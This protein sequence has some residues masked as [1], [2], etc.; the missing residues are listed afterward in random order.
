MAGAPRTVSR[1]CFPTVAAKSQG[2]FARR[3]VLPGPWWRNVHLAGRYPRFLA[4]TSPCVKPPPSQRLRM[5]VPPR[6]CRLSSIPAA[7]WFFPTLLPVFCVRSSGP[8]PRSSLPVHVLVTSRKASASPTA[9]LGLAHQ[10]LPA[11]QLRRGVRFRDCSHSLMFRLANSLDPLIAPTTAVSRWAAG[12]Y[13][14]RG[15]CL[16]TQPGSGIAT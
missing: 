10:R 9:L 8:L 2:S 11:M 6:P 16:V 12:P 5:P 15:T 4:H 3:R 1:A 7:G 14:P 13:T